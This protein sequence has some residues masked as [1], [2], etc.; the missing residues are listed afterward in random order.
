MTT[1]TDG[2]RIGTL[3]GRLGRV[4][5]RLEEQARAIQDLQADVRDVKAALDAGLRDVN[6]RIDR[7]FLAILGMGAAQ[8]ALLVTLIVRQG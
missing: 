3:E 1:T 8:I 2:E 4:E 7:M 6:G 5:G